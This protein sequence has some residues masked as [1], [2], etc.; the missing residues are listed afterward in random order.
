MAGYDQGRGAVRPTQF[1]GRAWREIGSRVKA[2]VS[3]DNLSVIAAG[4]AFYALFSLVPALAALVSI[5]GMVANPADI[6]SMLASAQDMLPRE[7]T[8]IIGSQLQQIVANSNSTLGV[9][10]LIGLLVALWS[11]TKGTSSM[12][13]ALN[14]AYEEPERRGFIRLNLTALLLTVG[15]IVGAVVAIALVVA[16]PALLTTLNPPEPVPTLVNWLRWPVLALAMMVGLALFYRY[17]P[18]R[19]RPRWQWV[20]LGSVAATLLW[21]VA[22]ALFSWYV[23]RF[24]SY[25]ETYGSMAAIIIL[26]MWL[27]ISAYVILL[28]AELNSELEHQTAQDTTVG[29]PKP[30]GERDAHMAD[31][32]AGEDKGKFEA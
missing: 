27:Y 15:A 22:S 26:L 18:S 7:V 12:M 8:G 4:V 3:G 20:S 21:L 16:A 14:I 29:R 2:E 28:G 1:G 11:A 9:G 32:V 13:T 6:E 23:S 25:N 10:A 24:G 31:R 30:L 19:N 5:Y 17:G